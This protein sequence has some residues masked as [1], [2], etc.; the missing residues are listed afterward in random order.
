MSFT[1]ADIHQARAIRKLSGI[2]Y[3]GHKLSIKTSMDNLVIGRTGDDG[4]SSGEWQRIV[5][6]GQRIVPSGQRIV[7]SGHGTIESIR[8]FIRSRYNNGFLNLENMAHDNILRAAKIIPPGQARG[9]GDVGTVMMKV[10]AELFPETTTI[11]F[12]MNGL[13]SLQPISA[14]SQF[15]PN[16]Q[17]LSLKSNDIQSYR[18]LEFLSGSRKLPKLRELILI[19]NP[20]RDRDIVK[21]KDD[22][23]YRSAVSKLFPTL[24]ILD[25]VPVAPKISF[26]LGDIL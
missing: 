2:R 21:N 25:Q 13:K 3:K 6:S 22:L 11:S 8:N 20:V 7:P 10:A 15:F 26:G 4:Q 18:D 5:P 14:V 24:Q 9:R 12:A 23:S 19:D 17:N 1:V 16:L